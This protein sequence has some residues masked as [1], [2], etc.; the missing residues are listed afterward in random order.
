MAGVE[1][2]GS[3][4]RKRN[5]N[6]SSDKAMITA[7]SNAAASNTA[8]SSTD[9]GTGQWLVTRDKVHCFSRGLVCEKQFVDHKLWSVLDEFDFA[10]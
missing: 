2:A 4:V 6:A 9:N 10:V 8:A 1:V 5:A 7:V 3:S